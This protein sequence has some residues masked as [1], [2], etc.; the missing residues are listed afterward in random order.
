MVDRPRY[1]TLPFPAYRFLPGRTPHP[2]RNPQGHSFGLPEPRPL[3][4]KHEVWSTSEDYL[5][6]VDLYNFDYWWEAH[7]VF[8]GLWHACGR[9]TEAGNFFQALI[10]VAGANIKHELGNEAA[11]QN[12]ARSGLLRLRDTPPRYMGLDTVAFADRV[13]LWLNR[14]QRPCLLIRLD[15]IAGTLPSQAKGQPG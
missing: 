9:N 11:A 15:G 10:Q 12:L 8:E 1:G 13:A 2:R 4:F 6:A 7:E 5:Y 14:G 3:P